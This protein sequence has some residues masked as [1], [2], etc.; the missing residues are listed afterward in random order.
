V[1]TTHTY[2]HTYTHTHTY[3]HKHKNTQT[4]TLSMCTQLKIDFLYNNIQIISN[5][6]IRPLEKQRKL[7]NKNLYEQWCQL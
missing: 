7:V 2:T 6:K 3:A 1:S 4:H 5:W